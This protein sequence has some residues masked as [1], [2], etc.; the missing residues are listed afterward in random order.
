[1]LKM[2]PIRCRIVMLF[3]LVSWVITLPAQAAIDVKSQKYAAFMMDSD[4][5]EVFFARNADARRHPASLTKM[6][7]LYLTFEA[8]AN[9][10]IKLTD[11]MP[12]SAHAAAQPQTNIGLRKGQSLPVD[13]AIRNLVVRSANDAAVVVAE[14]IGGTEWDF[15]LMM[16]AKARELGMKSTVFRNANGLPDVK[17]ITTAR[18][19]SKLGV[20][21]RRDFP[22]YFPYFKITSSSWNGVTYS[23]HNRVMLRYDGVDGIKTGYINMSGFNLVTSVVRDGHRLVGVVLGGQNAAVR[24]EHMMQLMDKTFATIAERGDEPRAFAAKVDAP[25]PTE[26]PDAKETTSAS[27]LFSFNTQP[28][29]SPQQTKSTKV[30]ARNSL[31][32]GILVASAHASKAPSVRAASKKELAD[33]PAYQKPEGKSWFNLSFNSGDDVAKPKAPSQ[34][35][36]YQLASLSDVGHSRPQPARL[37]GEWGIQVGAFAS[38]EAALQA[39][40][41]AMNSAKSQLKDSL[42]QVN[43]E[44]SLHRARIAN[45]SEYQA[46]SACKALVSGGGQC[47]VFR[48]NGSI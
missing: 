27:R 37:A 40:S 34:T 30:A 32:D 7:T 18:D 8:L 42:V 3:C 28:T 15:A 9:G 25:I 44:A 20:A 36:E 11:K 5:G 13:A 47:F 43:G 26:K 45:L 16:T 48:N 46:R 23:S 2:A 21:L 22:Q 14:Y 24:D 12:V 17:Q 1:M 33:A 19:M 41:N 4:T 6:M 29:V 39:A 31:D 38:R 10:K 35:L